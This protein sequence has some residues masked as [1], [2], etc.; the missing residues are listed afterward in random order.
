VCVL[1]KT[2]HVSAQV[3]HHQEYKYGT[4]EMKNVQLSTVLYNEISCMV[5]YI[6]THMYDG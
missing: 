3:S 4:S 1:Y 2:L 5:S 6:G